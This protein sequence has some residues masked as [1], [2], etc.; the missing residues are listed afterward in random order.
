[1]CT[2]T[3]A[4]HGQT[5]RDECVVAQPTAGSNLNT[6]N[7][8]KIYPPMCCGRYRSAEGKNFEVVFASSDK[9]EAGAYTRSHFSS[10]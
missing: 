8:N 2:G 6:P 7:L 4:H 1:V 10:T 5:V 3:P 9:S